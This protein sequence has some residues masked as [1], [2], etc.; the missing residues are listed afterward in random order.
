M[1]LPTPPKY[2]PVIPG[3]LKKN[4]NASLTPIIHSGYSSEAKTKSKFKLKPVATKSNS[5]TATL[6]ATCPVNNVKSAS[7]VVGVVVI[8][9]LLGRLFGPIAT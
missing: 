5:K 6:T 4:P 3:P 1:F 9:A 8:C 2:G 7:V